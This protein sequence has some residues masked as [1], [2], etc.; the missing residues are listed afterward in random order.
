MTIKQMIKTLQIIESRWGNIRVAHSSTYPPKDEITTVY[1]D[2]V[3]ECDEEFGGRCVVLA[4][5]DEV[6]NDITSED[7]SRRH[8]E[9]WMKVGRPAKP[10]K[11]HHI[12]SEDDEVT[13]EY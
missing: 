11:N 5:T 6:L 1:V 12:N 10:K 2:G 8:S 3:H 13:Y 4:P 7:Y 9:E